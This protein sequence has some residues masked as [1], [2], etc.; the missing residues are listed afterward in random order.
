M[1]DPLLYDRDTDTNVTA[2]RL[3]D[4]DHNFVGVSSFGDEIP[5]YCDV[6]GFAVGWYEVPD[7]ADGEAPDA[8]GH[9]TA[10]SVETITSAIA[11][12]HG[13]TAEGPEA[14]Q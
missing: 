14:D 9:A 1:V 6:C 12:K 13:A 8:L 3:L 11:M 2:S 5:D 4:D 10:F 7:A